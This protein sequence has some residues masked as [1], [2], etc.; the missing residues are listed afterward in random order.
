M[1]VFGG[2]GKHRSGLEFSNTLFGHPAPADGNENRFDLLDDVEWDGHPD[3]ISDVDPLRIFSGRHARGSA[4]PYGH[5]LASLQSQYLQEMAGLQGS[6]VRFGREES[7]ELDSPALVDPPNEGTVRDAG[8]TSGIVVTARRQRNRTPAQWRALEAQQ[9]AATRAEEQATIP[10]TA[11]RRERIDGTRQQVY[12]TAEEAG[13]DVE[14]TE[15]YIPKDNPGLA[16][17]RDHYRAMLKA[18]QPY[19][20]VRRFLRGHGIVNADTL[21]SVR[22]QLNFRRLHPEVPISAYSTGE[23]DDMW[24]EVEPHRV[25]ARKQKEAVDRS[26]GK[27]DAQDVITQGVMMGFTDEA[28]G[29]RA[30][31]ANAIT[32]PFTEEEFDPFKAYWIGKQIQLLRLDEARRDLCRA[33]V[34]LEVAG[35]LLFANPRAIAKLASPLQR[36]KA[37]MKQGATGGFISGYSYGDGSVDISRRAISGM[38]GGASLGARVSIAP[39]LPQMVT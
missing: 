30:A 38:G 6:L 26:R 3:P 8:D 13:P 2:M 5:H 16:G 15:D 1:G 25:E 19:H 37:A 28:T 10:V 24:V 22:Q 31:A 12:V 23:L 4:D 27:A 32:S 7:P 34:P 17:V 39:R 33:A 36:V 11:S 9:A 20:E 35:S 14:T 21:A 18:N 29:L